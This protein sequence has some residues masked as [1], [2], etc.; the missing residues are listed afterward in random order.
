M[1][2]IKVYGESSTGE[3]RGI[4]VMNALAKKGSN[5]LQN[6]ALQNQETKLGLTQKDS[7]TRFK[8]RWEKKTEK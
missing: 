5:P 7:L 8:K 6:K 1:V 4:R 3:Q 2:K